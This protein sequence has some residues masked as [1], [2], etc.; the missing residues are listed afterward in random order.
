MHPCLSTWNIEHALVPNRLQSGVLWGCDKFDMATFAIELFWRK[1]DTCHQTQ[2]LLWSQ[3][4]RLELTHIEFSTRQIFN[5]EGQSQAFTGFVKSLT[6]TF[7]VEDLPGAEL[8][9]G[10]FSTRQIFNREGQSQAFT[11]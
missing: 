2:T 9:M 8:D 4:N 7:S 3:L 6:L 1:I 11:G 10:K 5:R